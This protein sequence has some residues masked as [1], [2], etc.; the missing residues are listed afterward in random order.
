MVKIIF[1]QA[2]GTGSGPHYIWRNLPFHFRR[3]WKSEIN[4][5][6]YIM[7]KFNKILISPLQ[8]WNPENMVRTSPHA[9]IRSGGPDEELC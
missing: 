2:D 7:E 8:S 1:E 9:L 5:S 3:F 4:F 6:L